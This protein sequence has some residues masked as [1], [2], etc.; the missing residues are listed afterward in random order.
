M[1]LIRFV[2]RVRKGHLEV[3]IENKY[4]GAFKGK[5][6]R[7]VEYGLTEW[8]QIDGSIGGS[9]KAG[10]PEPQSRRIY[11]RRSVRKRRTTTT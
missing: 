8:R 4:F 6:L 2:S 7:Q 1:S 9:I 11:G 5:G 3:D 10:L